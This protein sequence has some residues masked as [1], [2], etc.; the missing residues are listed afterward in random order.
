MALDGIDGCGKSTHCIRLAE[1]FGSLG[2]KVLLTREPGGTEIGA[3]LRARL[4]SSKYELEPESEMMLFFVDRLEHLTKKVIPALN[5]GMVVISDRFTASTFAY[6]VFGRGIP[7]NVYTALERMALKIVPDVA[8][9]IDNE[10]ITCIARAKARLAED[11]KFDTEGK[12]EQL[13]YDFFRSVRNGFL[14]FAERNGYVRIV[15]GLGTVEEV[16]S[17]ILSNV[18]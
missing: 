2:R 11:G 9:I 17:R 3:E 4:L 12:F 1:Y 14:T 13:S 16:F 15:D 7:E 10:P 6:Q 18:R 5:E 8:V